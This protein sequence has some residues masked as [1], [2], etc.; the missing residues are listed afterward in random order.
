LGLLVG[1][2]LA[3]LRTAW[4]WPILLA[5]IF[6]NIFY[7]GLG[8]SSLKYIAMGEAAVFLAFGPLLIMGSYAV[9]T[10]SLSWDVF[11]LSLPTGILVALVLFANNLRD[12]ESDSL[13][14]IKTLATVMTPQA[15]KTFL[16]AMATFP[17]V[18]ICVYI[19]TRRLGG[20]AFLV[21]ASMGPLIKLI[22]V[23]WNGIPHAADAMMSRVTLLFNFFL[24][25]GIMGTMFLGQ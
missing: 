2:T 5:G 9:Q 20:P 23:F 19:L 6:L 4:L 21:F 11:L 15:G 7:T 10:R 16:A 1:G 13:K 14:N 12:R 24:V 18:L 3:W 8:R 17:Y 25:T 22:R